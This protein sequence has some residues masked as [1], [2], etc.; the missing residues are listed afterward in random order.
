MHDNIKEAEVLAIVLLRWVAGG[1]RSRSNISLA[2]SVA[3]V[4][5]ANRYASR[6]LGEI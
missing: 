3:D 6:T 1:D 2:E 5:A 4:F